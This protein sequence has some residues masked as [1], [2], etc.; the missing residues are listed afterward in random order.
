MCHINL[1]ICSFTPPFI[2]YVHQQIQGTS[3]KI[4]GV[5]FETSSFPHGLLFVACCRF[6]ST[7]HSYLQVPARRT[8]NIVYQEAL[9]Y[10]K[11]HP[12]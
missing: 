7:E 4:V 9:R 5:D 6:E 11:P 12:R 10:V 3:L 8:K 2:C 1:G